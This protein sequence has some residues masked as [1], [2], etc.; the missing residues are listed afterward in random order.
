MTRAQGSIYEFDGFHLDPEKRLLLG[1]DGRPLH[2]TPKAFDT[3]ICL[4]QHNDVVL[5]K[6]T[7]I[8]TIWADTAVEENNLNQCI[9]ALRRALGEKRTEPRYIATIPGRGYRFVARVNRRT[10]RAAATSSKPITSIAVL[11][12]QPLVISSRDEFLEMGMADTL[13]GR[14]SGIRNIVVRPMSSVRRYAEVHQDPLAAGRELGVESVL[15]GCLQRRGKRVRVTVRL[16]DV[17][18]GVSLWAHTFHNEMTD[19]F[20]LQDTIAEQVVQALSVELNKEDRTRLTKHST[21]NATA[22]QLYL[23]GRYYWW[24]N[25]P[26]EYE[27][28]RTYFHR[29]VEE[30]PS[31][32]L[33]YCGLNSF[34]GYGAAW[35][36]MPPDEGW[37]KAEWAVRKALELDDQLAEAHLDLAALKMVYYLDWPGTE[38]E[39]KRAIELDPKFDEIHYAYSFF[40]LV[41]R[42]FREATAEAKRALACNP[43]SV[44]IL[45]HLGYVLYCAGSFHQA[46]QHYK[47]ALELDP[48][49][50]SVYEALGETS[51]RAGNYREAVDYWTK[52]MSLE[53]ETK[54]LA[55]L[56]AADSAEALENARRAIA[57]ERLS[58]LLSKQKQ[59][60]YIP[61]IRIAQAHLQAG[62]REEGMD[63]LEKA[64]DERN[65]YSLLLAVDPLYDPLREDQRFNRLL[66]RM[67]L[68]K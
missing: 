23:K 32:A 19:I 29:A 46:N 55:T 56:R 6:E 11:P 12:F 3:L 37:P 13:I 18:N 60:D 66:R 9:S 53:N 64:C 40:L 31:F 34:Y 38:K 57:V 43:F 28:S 14:L 44:R 5:G 41:R 42:R 61:K 36:F 33:G 52:A 63:C 51:N 22:Y 35:G 21:Q 59:G 7:L 17:S 16:L 39:A 15:E 67:K 68:A 45:Q 26:A 54:L 50:A 30:D 4:V 1:R 25:S 58:R 2:V 10:P 62:H 47:K 65:V 48:K 20:A 8:K 49:D 24:K 27:K